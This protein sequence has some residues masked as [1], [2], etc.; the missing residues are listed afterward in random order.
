MPATS[1]SESSHRDPEAQGAFQCLGR[2]VEDRQEAV[3]GGL[4]L[5]PAELV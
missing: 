1:P 4:D 5:S 3:A 2:I